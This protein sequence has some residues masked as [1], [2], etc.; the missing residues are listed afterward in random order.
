MTLSGTNTY[1]VASADGKAVCIDPGPPDETHVGAIMRALAQLNLELVAIAVTHGHPDHA[2]AAA[3]LS[4]ATGVP[5]YGH[6]R[7]EFPHSET[8]A[9][10]DILQ[11]GKAR[12]RA[13]ETPGHT[14]DHL[15]FYLEDEQAL[16]TGDVV[17]GEGTVVIAPPEGAMRPYQATLERLARD[18]AHARKIYGGHGPPVDDPAAKLQKYIAHRQLR[19]REILTALERAPQTILQLVARIYANVDRVLWPAAERQ[20]LA[21]LMA[22]QDEWRV[23]SISDAQSGTR[24]VLIN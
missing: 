9:D 21:Y 22:L 17:L 4:D 20:V 16:F 24:Y 2:P 15:A 23:A 19:E 7:A 8:L 5:A 14:F 12:L 3:M 1:I 11:F 18:F 13:V 10:N 6:A